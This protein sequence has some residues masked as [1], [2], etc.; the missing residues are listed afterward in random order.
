MAHIFRSEIL[1]IVLPTNGTVRGHSDVEDLHTVL[2]QDETGFHI[3]FAYFL[4]SYIL[5]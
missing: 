3:P 4:M 5:T 1:L 2:H